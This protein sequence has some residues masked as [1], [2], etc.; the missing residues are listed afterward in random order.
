MTTVAIVYH[1]GYG[2]T[3]VVANEVAE[4]VRMAG[5][6][7]VVL[8]IEGLT[9]DFQPLLDEA[10][11]ADAIVFGSPTYM[12]DVSA[13]L[14][15]FFEAS[16]KIWYGQGWKDKVAGGFTNSY[17]QGGNKDNTLGSIIVLAMQH[18]MIWVGTGVMPAN[19]APSQETGADKVNRMSY[20]LG[21]A[22]QSDNAGADVT[23]PSGDK[24]TARLY[25]QRVAKVAAKL[26][27]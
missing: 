2:H 25:G 14:K 16:S 17:N 18:S 24:E 10:S 15:A 6:T 12:G 8:K 13:P 9:Q 1:S 19:P 3:A 7:P 22:S 4:G 11:K 21:L 5:A 27:G 20:M 23:P 26:K